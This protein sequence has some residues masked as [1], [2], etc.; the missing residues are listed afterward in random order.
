VDAL[1][2][3]VL[4]EVALAPP[5]LYSAFAFVPVSTSAYLLPSS[6][7]RGITL[8]FGYSAPHLGAS[9]TLT[10]L[11]DVLLST[12]FAYLA[13][14]SLQVRGVCSG[15]FSARPVISGK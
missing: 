8:A 10:L 15:Q 14:G 1:P 9:G 11:D 5:W 3:E 6:G 2:C 4:Q 13:F 12:R 7:R